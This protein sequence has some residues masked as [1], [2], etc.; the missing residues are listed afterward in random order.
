MAILHETSDV[1]IH[2]RPSGLGAIVQKHPPPH[3]SIGLAPSQVSPHNQ[4]EV[5]QRLYG[6]DG[7]GV[8]DRVRFSKYKGK[9]EKG[10]AVNWGYMSLFSSTGKIW[11]DEG[12]GLTRSD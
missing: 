3:R 6:Y 8:S 10:Y 2:R 11:Q 1:A 4:E 9:F 7:K 5:W 12:N